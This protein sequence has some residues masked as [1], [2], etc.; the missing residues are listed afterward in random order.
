MNGEEEVLTFNLDDKPLPGKNIHEHIASIEKFIRY[1]E[2]KRIAVASSRIA[3]Y[4]KFLENFPVDTELRPKEN[5]E[6]HKLIDELLY[7]YREVHEIMW[8]QKGLEKREPAGI[9]NIMR[10]IVGGNTYAR[11][12]TD[13]KARNYQFELRIASYFLQNNYDVNLETEADVVVKNTA[14]H[15]VIECKRLYSEKNAKKRISEAAKQLK[16]KVGKQSIFSR[17]V[18]IAV[19]DVTKLAYPHQGLTWGMSDEHCKKLIQDKLQYISD[20]YDFEGPFRGN[21]NVIGIWMQIHIPSLILQFGQ[22]TTRFSSLFTIMPATG[23]RAAAFK[24]FQKVY[25]VVGSEP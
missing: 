1:L 11:D 12:D 3:K 22:P 9:D 6:H 14:A 23:F 5:E 21:K 18:G 19:F 20:N 16:K 10:T 8:I 4:K 17:K 7:V 15:F 24:E 13:T 25:E 2:G